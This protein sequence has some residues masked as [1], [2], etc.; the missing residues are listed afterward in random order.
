M[1][2]FRVMADADCFHVVDVTGGREPEIAA[3]FP[4]QP[5]AM[6]WLSEHLRLLNMVD[7]LRWAGKP[8]NTTPVPEFGV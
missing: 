2:S 1:R 8:R 3:S 6:G 5:D 4:S 7:L